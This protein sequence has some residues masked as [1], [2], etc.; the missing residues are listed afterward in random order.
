MSDLCDFSLSNLV[1]D[2]ICDKSQSD[3]STDAMLTNR[4]TRSFHNTSLIETGLS[5][6]HKIIVSVFRAFFKRFRLSKVIEY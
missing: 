5:N 3:T 6:C 4:P 2:I 1:N